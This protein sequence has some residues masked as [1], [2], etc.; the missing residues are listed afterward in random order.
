YV[1]ELAPK[2]PRSFGAVNDTD[3]VLFLCADDV[4]CPQHLQCLPAGGGESGIQGIENH[5]GAIKPALHR[6]VDAISL[7]SGEVDAI[8]RRL[9]DASGDAGGL[10][11]A[12][13]VL[14]ITVV[15]CR[16]HD[17]L[18]IESLCASLL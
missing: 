16:D 10:L 5:A 3:L 11:V 12:E 15:M 9:N 8:N 1:V 6:L 7:A 2:N 4:V 17:R 14:V 13:V 18:A